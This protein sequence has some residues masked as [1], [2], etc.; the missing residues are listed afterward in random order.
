MTMIPVIQT[1]A[2]F[3]FPFALAFAAISDL[4]TMTIS[5]R[6]VLVL[7]AAF[8]MLAPLAGLELRGIGLDLL[9]AFI[10]LAVA[11]ACFAAGWI[12]GGDA[13]F[14]AVVTLWIGWDNALAFIAVSA[15]C[16]GVLTLTIL[17]FRR[18]LLPA[19]AMR[20]E[21]VARLHDNAS[22]VP[23]GVALAVGG[24]AVY[25]HTAWMAMLGH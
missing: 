15:V 4:F 9:A 12:G 18:L 24:L 23:Y 20:Q 17:R 6:L 25:P 1:I 2:F 13:K 21:W 14:A 3:V 22:G 19:F 11:F 8:I 5:N 16:G 7:A 10:V